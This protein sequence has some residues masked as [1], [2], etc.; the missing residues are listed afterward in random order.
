MD[1]EPG[2]LQNRIEVAPLEGRGRESLER[3]R[4]QENEGEEG[5]ADQALNGE[6]VGAQGAWQSAAKQGDERAEDRQNEDPQQ[7]RAFVVPPH[8]RDFVDRGHRHVRVLGDV[9]NGK[10]RGQ[11]RIDEGCESERDQRELDQ[12]RVA[13]DRHESNVAN[14]SAPERDDRLGERGGERQHKGEMADFNNHCE[15]AVVPSCQ[16][17]CFFSASTTS[18]GI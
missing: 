14:A 8:A 4:G 6:R 10:I 11:V 5:H 15:A 12:R 7:H 17:P 18:R 13:P 2:V 16:R 1:R 3:V 9:E